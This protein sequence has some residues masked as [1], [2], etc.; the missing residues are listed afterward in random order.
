MIKLT[1]KNGLQTPKEVRYTGSLTRITRVQ[2]T[3]IVL[4]TYRRIAALLAFSV[5]LLAVSL[6]VAIY[7]GN[8]ALIAF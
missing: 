7:T 1:K 6:A 5:A 4:I 3:T 2:N 8:T